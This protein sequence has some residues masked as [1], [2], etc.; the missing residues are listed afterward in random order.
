MW[1]REC[2][3]NTK[4]ILFCCSHFSEV[5]PKPWAPKALSQ[6]ENE[7]NTSRPPFAT[8]PFPKKKW[9]P[10][11]KGSQPLPPTHQPTNPTLPFLPGSPS[12]EGKMPRQRRHWHQSN[13]RDLLPPPSPPPPPPLGEP[14]PETLWSWWFWSPKIC[15]HDILPSKIAQHTKST[16]G[17]KRLLK[18]Q[19]PSISP[20][21]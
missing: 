13:K 5:L 3:S 6:Q 19:C 21:R 8:C 9:H 4:S 2:N 15:K 14:D 20:T 10:K 17:G 7:Q 12:T 18:W 11:K 16:L 1:I